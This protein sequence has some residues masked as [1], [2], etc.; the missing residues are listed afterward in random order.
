[1]GSP[2]SKTGRRRSSRSRL[3]SG[4]ASGRIAR[5]PVGIPWSLSPKTGSGARFAPWDSFVRPNTEG[6]EADEPERTLDRE[7]EPAATR[8]VLHEAFR[9]TELGRGWLC[10]LADRKRLG[11]HRTARS[12][13]GKE[14]DTGSI[15][16][17]HRNG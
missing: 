16:L 11:D 5:R 17:E 15:D 7:R 8:R 2:G 3:A 6:G 14:R 13:Q 12:G 9:Q 4:R 1:G 10:R